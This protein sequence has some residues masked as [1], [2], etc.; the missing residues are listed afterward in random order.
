MSE[1][2]ETDICVIGAGSGGLSVAAG[3]SQMGARVVLIEKGEMGGDCLNYGCVPSK[4]LIA[5]AR[6]AQGRRE[7]GRFGL[8][9]PE[10]EIDMARVA[11][12]VRGVIAAIEPNDSQERFEGM[13]VQ[14]IRAE[15]RFT[16]ER[17]LKAGDARVRAKYFVIATGS[18]PFVPPIPGLDRVP[19]LTN[20]TLFEV[21]KPIG[22]LLVVG[23]GPIGLEM[24]QAHRR[25][26]ADVTVVEA[27][28][29]MGKDDPEAAAVV[30]ERLRAEG[31]SFREGAKA[32]GVAQGDDGSIRLTVETEAGEETLEGD[33][34]L[35]AVGR[36]ANVDSLDLDKAGVAF[37]RR[38]VQVDGRLRTTNR[39]I[40]A[41]GDVAGG[42]QFTHMAGYHAGVVI[43]QMLFKMIWAKADDPAAPWVTYTDPE[44]AQVGLSEAQAVER[45]GEGAIKILRWGFE[46]N[47]RA[48]AE[49]DLHG[50]VKAVLDRQGRVLGATIV[51]A[52][53][54]ELLLPWSIM[55]R[56]RL[57]ISKLA[58]VIVPYPTRSEASKRAAGSAFTETLF[59]DRTKKI[60]RF[61]LRF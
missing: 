20:E 31:V 61:L 16:G 9:A 3:A 11:A 7:G 10:P 53:A 54:G 25:L 1:I 59:S 44:L 50:F 57:K 55:V 29:L 19:Y 35:I 6:E 32:S 23:G 52:H 34:L 24:A 27:A 4:A 15:A 30:I 33:R 17:E 37:D 51:G 47:D 48:Q 18:S 40:F 49:R 58:S 12:H 5:A 45:F 8:D 42:L 22:R 26:G 38:G 46:E 41:I 21:D 28:R 36:A 2:I 39:R 43:R 60:V 14:V 13:G 56:E